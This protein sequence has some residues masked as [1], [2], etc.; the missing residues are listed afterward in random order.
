MFHLFLSEYWRVFMLTTTLD[1]CFFYCFH[2]VTVCC[3]LLPVEE[4]MIGTKEER[5]ERVIKCHTDS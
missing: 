4:A 5:E 3:L 2:R 1:E